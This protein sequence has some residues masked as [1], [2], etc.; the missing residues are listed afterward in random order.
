[1]KS[2]K[3]NVKD[4]TKLASIERI[5]FFILAK[6]SKEVNEISKFFKSKKL[7]QANAG[8][9]ESYVQASNTS[10]NTESILKIKE[11][12]STLKVKRIN[13]I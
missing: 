9:N 1:V 4:T 11:A 10:S 6:T 8:P 13:N 3:P 12:F 5:S 7:A 2:G